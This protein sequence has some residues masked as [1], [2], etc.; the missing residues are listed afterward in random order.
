MCM[1]VVRGVRKVVLNNIFFPSFSLYRVVRLPFH[2]QH[3]YLML[4]YTLYLMAIKLY[5]ACVYYCNFFFLVHWWWWC[6]GVMIGQRWG[7]KKKLNNFTINF[8]TKFYFWMTNV[9]CLLPGVLFF[10]KARSIWHRSRMKHVQKFHTFIR[11]YEYPYTG[12]II[13]LE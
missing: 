7:W 2:F 13:R 5:T 1:H 10:I 4:L 8:V 9:M 6:D 12:K 11:L 3:I